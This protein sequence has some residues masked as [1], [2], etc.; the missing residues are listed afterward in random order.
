MNSFQLNH[1][2]LKVGTILWMFA[3]Q[4]ERLISDGYSFDT[5]LGPVCLILQTLCVPSW[6]HW[7]MHCSKLYGHWNLNLYQWR[8]TGQSDW[9][10]R[11]RWTVSQWISFHFG[12]AGIWIRMQGLSGPLRAPPQGTLNGLGP[13]T[14]LDQKT[15]AKSKVYQRPKAKDQ[16]S[17]NKSQVYQGRSCVQ[18]ILICTCKL[19]AMWI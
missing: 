19:N 9:Q 5:R 11:H 10:M 15:R 16:E 6:I 3:M 18:D 8:L 2:Q 1:S 7:A 12:F 4:M 17:W 13:R 14:Q